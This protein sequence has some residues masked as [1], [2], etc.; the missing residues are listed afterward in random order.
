MGVDRKAIKPDRKLLIIIQS[1]G[2]RKKNTNCATGIICLKM[3]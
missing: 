3:G 2:A 1:N